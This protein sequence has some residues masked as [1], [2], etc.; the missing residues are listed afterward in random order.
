MGVGQGGGEGKD[1]G[2]EE[3]DIEVEV[4]EEVL[5]EDGEVLVQL[6]RVL[7]GGE[8]DEGEER[9]VGG[10][11]EGD[12]EER[13]A[14]VVLGCG[15]DVVGRADGEVAWCGGREVAGLLGG[16]GAW[17]DEVEL[18]AEVGVGDGSGLGEGIH[19]HCVGI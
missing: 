7:S 10:V 12:G 17:R 9:G 3:V 4:F 15:E 8:D 19:V 11:R 16:S 2:F 18:A 1:V 6:G 14:G 5:G 13:W